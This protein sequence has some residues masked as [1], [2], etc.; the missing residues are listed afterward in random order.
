MLQK[1]LK[2]FPSK[3]SKLCKHDQFFFY[4]FFLYNISV[5]HAIAH[6]ISTQS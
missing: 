2:I 4:T 3:V 6:H 1:N 5:I